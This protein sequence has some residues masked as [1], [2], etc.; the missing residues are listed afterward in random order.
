MVKPTADEVGKMIEQGVSQALGQNSQ[1]VDPQIELKK[2]QDDQKKRSNILSFLQ[3]YNQDYQ[4]LRQQRLE[5]A[6]RKQVNLQAEQQ[7]K[8]QVK[9]FEVTKKTEMTLAQQQAK[10]RAERKGGVG[11]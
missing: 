5:E 4:R 9:Q 2:K 8:L 7:K 3:R 11:G 10:A 6:Q 1:P